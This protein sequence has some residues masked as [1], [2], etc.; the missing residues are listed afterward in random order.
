MVNSRRKIIFSG[1]LIA[2][3]RKKIFP[4]PLDRW[5]DERNRTFIFRRGKRRRLVDTTLEGQLGG[6]GR[7]GVFERHTSERKIHRLMRRNARSSEPIWNAIVKGDC[8][9]HIG[10]SSL[11][12]IRSDSTLPKLFQPAVPWP[13]WK[14]G[15]A[16]SRWEGGG[17][18]GV[19]FERSSGEE[20]KK[21]G[22][23]EEYRS[24]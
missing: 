23:S 4:F 24:I 18:G 11:H 5:I 14:I 6:R 10:V 22:P 21:G 7:I 13:P 17:G 15:K 19:P 8:T 2:R 20:D 12:I 3:V 1:K 9:L 16:S